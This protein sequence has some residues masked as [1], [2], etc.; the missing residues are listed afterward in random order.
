MSDPRHQYV[1]LRLEVALEGITYVPSVAAVLDI[2]M[3]QDE[4]VR[5][6]SVDGPRCVTFTVDKKEEDSPQHK[7]NFHPGVP[8]TGHT[9]RCSCAHLQFVCV[10]VCVCSY[11]CMSVCC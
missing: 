9:T 5:F 6:Y 7:L 2:K 10:C 8:K 3:V 4:L 11:L 1:A